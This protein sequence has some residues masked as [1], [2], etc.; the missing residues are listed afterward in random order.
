MDGEQQPPSTADS[1]EKASVQSPKEVLA[2]AVSDALND[3]KTCVL[4]IW[5]RLPLWAQIILIGLGALCV[6]AWRY[7]ELVFGNW[8]RVG[9]VARGAFGV[10][11]RVGVISV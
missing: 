9:L 1:P 5:R 7:R 3:R 6:V 4:A 2:A 11:K 10:A 8:H